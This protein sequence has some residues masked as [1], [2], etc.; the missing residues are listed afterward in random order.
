MRFLTRLISFYMN[1]SHKAYVTE[2]LLR[3]Y[4]YRQPIRPYAFIRV[5]NEI[6]TIDAS[7]HSI[8]PLLE[9]GVIG[10]NSCTDGTKEY[11]E[12]FCKR[13]PQFTC[14]EYPY[15]VIPA[16]DER[17]KQDILPSELCLDSYYNFVWEKLP[18]NK[19][20]IKLDAD[21]LWD[22]KKTLELCKI[23][24]REKDVVVLS[25]INL[26][27]HNGE[28]YISRKNPIS[29]SNDSWIIFNKNKTFNMLRGWNKSEFF[30]YE[31]LP[32]PKNK[33][34]RIYTPVT[35]WHFPIVKT[36]RNR[37]IEDDWVKLSEFDMREYIKNNK[38]F[39]RV[40]L[41]MI[42]EKRILCE[43]AKFNIK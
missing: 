16:C 35:N 31:Y 24:V 18:L 9:G 29:E 3:L 14:I 39:G 26:H 30:A 10:F 43:Y 13:Y 2:K 6:K 25:R 23:P 11:V 40:P 21:H 32:L 8:L 15:D 41:D 17:Y 1:I 5:C 34:R 42:D 22:I 37:F 19:W 28:V 27:V 7:L 36:Q 4:R 20:I 33:A 38:L 12:D